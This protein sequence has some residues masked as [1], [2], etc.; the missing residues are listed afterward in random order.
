MV[1]SILV[2]DMEIENATFLMPYLYTT[3]ENRK[4]LCE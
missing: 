1:D 2:D 4:K 3:G